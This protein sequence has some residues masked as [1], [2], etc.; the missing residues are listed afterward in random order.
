[1]INEEKKVRIILPDKVKGIIRTLENH[2]FEAYAVGGCVRDAILGRTPDD[3]DITTSAR[4][5]QVKACFSRTVDTGLQHGTVTVL[6]GRETF[7]VTTY[8]ID[9]IYEDARHPKEVTFTPSLEEDLMR[10]DFTINAMAYNERHGLVDRFDGMRDIRDGVVR[11]V[12]DPK[13][14]F[15][16]DALR[17]MR[18]VR[19]AAQLGFQIDPATKEQIGALAPRLSMISAERIR[20]ELV[21]LLVSP[22]P[23]MLQVMYE[24]GLTDIF[25]PE[26]SALM[27]TPQNS[28]HHGES[29]GEHTIEALRHVQPDQNLRLAMLFHDIAKPLCRTTD[30]NGEDHFHGHPQKGAEMTKQ[31]LRRLK[32]DNDTIRHVSSLVRIHDERIYRPVLPDDTSAQQKDTDAKQMRAVRRAVSRNGV[33][34]YP[35]LFAV[36]RADILA[37]SDYKRAEKLSAVDGYERLWKEIKERNECLSIKDLAVDGRALIAEGI[38]QGPEIGRVLHAMLE[39]VLEYP[40]HNDRAYL[41]EHLSTFIK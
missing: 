24:T 31:I 15:T 12:G 17:M 37:Q 28:K 10:R 26:F 6:C 23:E 8:R 1:M 19:F 16:E 27:H 14:R 7:E 41:L 3:W 35:D 20:T 32:F 9:G 13:E 21:K 22:H 30:E 40:E 2:G 34:M 18:A 5:E 36:M 38:S 25:L 4:P 39:H 11:C 29:A 33:D